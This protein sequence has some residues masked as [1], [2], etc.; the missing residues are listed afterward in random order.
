LFYYIIHLF[1][2]ISLFYVFVFIPGRQGA[3][4]RTHLVSPAMAAAAAVT[5]H[6]ADVRALTGIHVL[7]MRIIIIINNNGFALFIL[8]I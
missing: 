1:I 7:D 4:G 8:W 6:L 2:I 3:K 5:G